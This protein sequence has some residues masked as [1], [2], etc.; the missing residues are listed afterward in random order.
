MLTN[1]TPQERVATT[2]Q[3]FIFSAKFPVIAYT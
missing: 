3:N 1:Y 2:L